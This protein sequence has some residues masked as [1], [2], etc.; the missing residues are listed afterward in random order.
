MKLWSDE[1]RSARLRLQL[2]DQSLFQGETVSIEV[3]AELPPIKQTK[4]EPLQDGA[5]LQRWQS[6]CE[7]AQVHVR[8]VEVS[9][10]D[11]HAST[12]ST[13]LFRQETQFSRITAD[14]KDAKAGS[15]VRMRAQFDLSVHRESWGRAVSLQVHVTPRRSVEEDGRYGKPAGLT[16]ARKLGGSLSLVDEWEALQLLS[17]TR[18]EAQP[19]PSMARQ[20]EQ[21][22]VVTK[23]LRLDVETRNLASSRVGILAR[24]M[25]AHPTQS[26]EVR[27]LHL[28]LDQM[29]RSSS[30]Q[31]RI[32]SGDKVPFP[33]GLRP[34]ERYNFLFELEPVEAVVVDESLHCLDLISDASTGCNSVQTRSKMS[35]AHPSST[36]QQHTLLTLSWKVGD[37]DMDPIVENRTV[38]WSSKPAT[39]LSNASKPQDDLQALVASVLPKQSSQGKILSPAFKFQ[40]LLPESVLQASIAPLPARIE[41]GQTVT[42]CVTV[43]NRSKRSDFDLTLLLPLQKEVASASFEAS[44]RLGLIRPGM[45]IRKSVHVTFLHGGKCALGPLALADDLTRTCFVSS[46]GD[47]CQER[48]FEA[49][50]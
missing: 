48:A 36:L 19:T 49:T 47:S 26:L 42:V 40:R 35:A 41:A 34:H 46:R 6:H 22:I 11:P 45:S 12:R 25:N 15:V 4:Q 1:W 32:V 50:S 44:Q 43:V 7:I 38:A 21:Q 20:V 5:L 31:F 8:I 18:E 27:D 10:T 33:V 37:V 23:P 39:P 30:R 2:R 3:C 16:G 9:G 28:H 17:L 13:T 24:V 14:Q 29:Q